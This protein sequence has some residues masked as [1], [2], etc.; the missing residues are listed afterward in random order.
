MKILLPFILA[1]IIGCDEDKN[2]E[3]QDLIFLRY[4]DIGYCSDLYL[5][6]DDT[7][8]FWHEEDR[9]FVELIQ[10]EYCPDLTYYIKRV[11]QSNKPSYCTLCIIPS[12]EQ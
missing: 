6:K 1:A 7:C 12:D 10:S 9:E 8:D 4:C 11:A 5:K 2:Q 3:E